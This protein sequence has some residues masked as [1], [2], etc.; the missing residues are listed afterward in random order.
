MRHILIAMTALLLLISVAFA[1]QA[2]QTVNLFQT[3]NPGDTA[4]Y[5]AKVQ[6]NGK[7][8]LPGTSDLVPIDVIFNMVI[9]QSVVKISNESLTQ[10]DIVSENASAVMAGQNL[11]LSKDFFPKLTVLIDK[12]G[13]IT[14]IISP[15]PL[16]VKLPG[17]NYRNLILLFRTFAPSEALVAGATWSKSLTLAPEPEKYC[18]NYSLESIEPIDG[19]KTAKVRTDISITSPVDSGG[20]GKGVAVTS[21]TRSD[22]RL[23]KSHAEMTVKVP[24]PSKLPDDKSSTEYAITTIKVD[25]ARVTKPSGK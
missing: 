13:D 5:T 20:V 16:G 1:D 19:V 3:L 25:I 12:N 6:I 18:L 17:L 14:Q 8:I 24:L 15:D 2:A 23:L 11:P 10:L 7:T 4:R 22:A 9:A 21:F